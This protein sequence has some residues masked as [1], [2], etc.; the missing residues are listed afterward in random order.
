MRS[1]LAMLLLA[2]AALTLHAQ[3]P[4]QIRRAEI[5]V[6]SSGRCTIEVRVDITAEVDV[7]GDSG[8]LR[9]IAGQPASWSRF[10]CTAPMPASM[11]EFRLGGVDGRG[12]VKLVQ[13]PRTNNSIAVVRIEDPR[14]GAGVYSFDLEWS[15]ASG[16]A[17]A[18]VF[19]SGARSPTAAWPPADTQADSTRGVF[20]SG[21]P[22]PQRV[23][24]ESAIDLCRTELRARAESDYGLRSVEI[25][26]VAADSGPAR[27]DWITGTLTERYTRRTYRFACQVDYSAGQVRGI[28][29]TGADGRALQPLVK[30]GAAAQTTLGG[31]D[32][33]QALRACQDAVVARAARDGYQNASFTS[34]VPDATRADRISGAFTASRGPVVDSFAFTCLMERGAARVLSVEVNRR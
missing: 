29:I 14:G 25:V 21:D 20:Y 7:Y 19:E 6:S 23:S 31:Y 5:P 2:G 9:T 1:G 12:S 16:K 33:T 18:G 8:R 10:T 17:A 24:T 4:D 28:E 11:K 13:D 15:G 22:A 26:S 34:T 32:Q 30:S 27:R 3:A